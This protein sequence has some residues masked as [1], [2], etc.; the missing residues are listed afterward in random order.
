MKKQCF[1]I[2]QRR[3][4]KHKVEIQIVQQTLRKRQ[5][6]SQRALKGLTGQMRISDSDGDEQEATQEQLRPWRWSVRVTVPPIQNDWEDDHVSFV[7]VTETGD[8]NTYR[9]AIEADDHGK[10]ITA[11]EQVSRPASQ[12]RKRSHDEGRRRIYARKIPHVYTLSL[13]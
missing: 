1:K 2:S 6:S 13:K 4:T 9:E 12:I 5:L 3:R 11:M 8:T 10:W 7:L